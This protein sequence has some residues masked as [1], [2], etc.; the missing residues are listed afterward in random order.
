MTD[1]EA[2]QLLQPY[3]SVR[4]MDQVKMGGG[5]GFD[6]SL[7]GYHLPSWGRP[8]GGAKYQLKLGLSWIFPR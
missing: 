5:H 1:S 2:L 4:F 6:I 7:G 8:Q 3:V